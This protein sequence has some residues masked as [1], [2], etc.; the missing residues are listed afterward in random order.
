VAILLINA[1]TLVR[2][3][4]WNK[5]YTLRQELVLALKADFQIVQS[6]DPF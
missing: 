1:V 4:E 3:V 5:T 6:Q 2:Y